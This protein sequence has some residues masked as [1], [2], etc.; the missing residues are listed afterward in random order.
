M[1]P[2]EEHADVGATRILV[3]MSDAARALSLSRAYLYPL[4]MRGDILSVKIGT[5]RRIPW[6]ALQD[7]VRK[8]ISEQVN[9]EGEERHGR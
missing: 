4:V 1:Q 5:V 3:T 2:Q 6:D 9:Y 8:L 7:Y